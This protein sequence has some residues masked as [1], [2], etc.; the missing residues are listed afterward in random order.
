MTL[1]LPLLLL[2]VLL[3]A[4]CSSGG[5]D[6]DGSAPSYRPV[7]DDELY[8][9]IAQLPGVEAVDIRYDDTWPESKYRGEITIESGA[10]PQ[11]VLD[12]TYAVL[13]QGRPDV[14]ISVRGVQDRTSISFD[15]LDGRSGIPANLEKRYGPQPGDGT[16]P[17]DG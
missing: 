9:R 17:G 5:S 14:A 12:A 8:A 2:G 1:R 10:D 11:A 4:A 13:R 6:S 16:P 15:L 3:L 7:P